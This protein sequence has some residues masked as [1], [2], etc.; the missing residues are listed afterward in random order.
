[1]YSQF[2]CKNVEVFI[3]SRK[4]SPE[5][6]TENVDIFAAPHHFKQLKGWVGE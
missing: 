2:F 3:T 1:M 4:L 6:S 5:L